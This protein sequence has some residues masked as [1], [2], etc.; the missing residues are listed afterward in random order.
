[1]GDLLDYLA[2]ERDR[3]QRPQW[4]YC[5]TEVPLRK[6]DAHD[7]T[8]SVFEEHHE[9]AEER[10]TGWDELQAALDK[11]IETNKGIVSYEA[12]YSRKVRIPE[13]DE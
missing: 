8:Y 7:V 3:E 4:A 2:D 5:C 1:M 6:M 11:F 10:A 12:D 13:N 9:G